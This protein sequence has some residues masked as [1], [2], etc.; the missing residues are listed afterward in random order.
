MGFLEVVCV[1]AGKSVLQQGRDAVMYVRPGNRNGKCSQQTCCT[2]GCC[3]RICLGRLTSPLSLCDPWPWLVGLRLPVENH[4]R[5]F[6]SG[7]LLGFLSCYK[8]V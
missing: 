5:W 6:E 3:T 8:N 1:A 4:Q 7:S 2:K